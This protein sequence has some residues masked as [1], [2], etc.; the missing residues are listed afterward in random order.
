MVLMG[1]ERFK[2]L[3]PRIPRHDIN[4]QQR[5]IIRVLAP[6]FLILLLL[7]ILGLWQLNNIIRNQAIS[8]LER[9]ASST[10]AKLEREFAIR[11]AVL[12][13][14]GEELFTIKSDYQVSRQKLD[15][16]RAACSAW[17]NQK[18]SYKLAPDGICT[19]FLAEFANNGASA[20]AVQTSYVQ[21][22]TQIAKDQETEVNDR[23]SAYKQFFPETVALLVVDK[24][25]QLV[26][27]A[28]SDVVQGS[29]DQFESEAAAAQTQPVEGKLIS[30]PEYRLAIFA[31]PITGG[32]VLAA[33]DLNNDAFIHQSWQSTPIDTRK[34]LA[35]I[36]DATDQTAYPNIKLDSS[37][38]QAAGQLRSHPSTELR[39][40]NIDHIAVGAQT[41]IS[42]WMV[43]VASPK[44]VVF[45]PLRDAQIA[46]VVVVGLLLVGFLWV[47][48][49]FIRRTIDSIVRL[50]GGALVFASGTLDYKIHLT[51]ADQEFVQLAETMN[52][53]AE[54]IAAAEKE[55]DEKNKEFISI[56]TH[57]LRTP[58]TAIG[59]YL[60]MINDDFHDKL[61]PAVRPLFEQASR[62]TERLRELVNDM[63]DM[64]R[65]EGGRVEFILE[66]QDIKAVAA[67][68]VDELRITAAE[69]GI[70]LVYDSAAAQTV[71][72]DKAK[73][74]IIFNNFVSNAIK[75]NRPSGS[76]TLSHRVNG[77]Q[78]VTMI[79][80]TGLGIPDDQ[81]QHMFEKFF[82]V[83]NA[84]RETVT[85][86]G[87]GMY[88]TKQYIEAM[89]G[90]LWFESTHGKGTTFYFSLP[91]SENRQVSSPP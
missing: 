45:G 31:Y 65:L 54:R 57:E 32:S 86:T 17:L 26:S 9:S 43:I 63:L 20:A 16:D 25:K 12:K 64:A 34:A 69:K 11:Q 53:M 90:K 35:V 84:D 61:D 78:L 19:P 67:D 40:R 70:Q 18:K 76:V 28:I 88:I 33:Y 73:L 82:R 77:D 89:K 87:L 85:G 74:H 5:F 48:I 2:K 91:L 22:G 14:T 71:L 7:G 75:Y 8:D 47:G 49:I 72:A 36:V 51:H 58:L 13:R 29:L 44:A 68:V 41:D 30:T 56:A 55:I 6:P 3:R 24:N 81:K 83:K 46:T 80:D 15:D 27:S 50:V 21:T 39:L 10:A 4:L 79:T 59:G 23:L 60:S 1:G 38:A 42:K 66:P 37:F 62:G 52:K